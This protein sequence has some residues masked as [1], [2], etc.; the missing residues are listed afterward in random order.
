MR[1]ITSIF[2]LV[3]IFLAYDASARHKSKINCLRGIV[4]FENPDKGKAPIKATGFVAQYD[5][6]FV[7]FSNLN[8]V[9]HCSNPI[10]KTIDGKILKYDRILIPKDKRNVLYFELL[11]SLDTELFKPLEFQ[12]DLTEEINIKAPIMAF[13]CKSNHMTITSSKGNVTAIGPKTIEIASRVSYNTN[14]GPVLTKKTGKVLGA[15]SILN[16]GKKSKVHEVVRI[17]TVEE[18]VPLDQNAFLKEIQL[19]KKA[20]RIP[21][22]IKRI[23][24]NYQ[25]AMAQITEKVEKGHGTTNINPI[26]KRYV[27]VRAAIARLSTQ[28]NNLGEFE[29][30]YFTRRVQI[31]KN[32]A[33]K[34]V[35]EFNEEMPAE[36]E[37][38]I[39]KLKNAR[40]EDKLKLKH[41]LK[42]YSL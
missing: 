4:V 25:N 32:K 33:E 9:F 17:D 16:L 2:L 8:V 42:D 22:R 30:T 10:I 35:T 31:A 36:L 41:K 3:L 7:V 12:E 34:Y 21:I 29:F 20:K 14:G 18:F 11:P 24:Q 28:L 39:K 23:I 37:S 1:F 5:G 40:K 26:K 15:I 6:K 38:L 27:A 19:M 13:G